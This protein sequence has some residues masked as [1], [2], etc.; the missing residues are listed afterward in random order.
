MSKVYSKSEEQQRVDFVVKQIEHTIDVYSEKAEDIDSNAQEIRKTFWEDV[1]VNFDEP[2]DAAETAASI[3]QQV[4]L[5]SERERSKGIIDKQL[6]HLSRLKNSP[7]FGRIDF[8][9]KD[10]LE[11]EQVYLGIASFMDDKH[12]QFL[13]YDWRAPISS[14]YYDYSPGTAEY[15]T[16]SGIIRGEMELKRQFIIQN[17]VIEG[18]FDT[19][20][21]IG[22]KLLQEVLSKQA[23][24]QMKN[25]V[26]TIQKEQNAIIRNE[27]SKVLVVQGV[28]GSGKTSAALQ[29]VA[30]LLYRY[31]ETLH[32]DQIMLFS[33]NPLFN[34]YIATVLPELG[35]ENM[36]QTTYQAYL[37]SRLE[38]TFHLEDAFS[39][40]ES[41]LTSEESD[42]L[43]L[44]IKTIQFKTSLAFKKLMDDYI[45]SLSKK[46]IIFNDL[47]FRGESVLTKEQIHDRFY[48]FDSSISIPNR[49][50]LIKEWI[51]KEIKIIEKK[52]RNQEWVEDE[53]GLLSKEDYYEVHKQIQKKYNRKDD[54]FNDY[55]IERKLLAKIIVSKKFKSL[56]RKMKQYQFIN[57][58]AIYENVFTSTTGSVP[59]NWEDIC[60]FS[61]MKLKKNEMTYED[62]TPYLYLQDKI[63]GKKSN[64]SI[65]HLII[66]EAQDYSPL[67]FAYIRDLFPASKMT[68]LGDINQAIHI[69]ADD[70]EMIYSNGATDFLELKR[71]YRSTRQIVEFTKEVIP[72]GDLI[73]AFNREGKKPVLIEVPNNDSLHAEMIRSI[74]AF[75]KA[76]Y[77]SIAI[78]CKT[79][80]ESS[81]AYHA[82][83]D[84]I[85]VSLIYKETLTYDTGVLILPAYLAKGIEFDAVVIYN[86]SDL[87]YSKDRERKLFY[88][89]C[90]RAM[91]ELLLFSVGEKTRFIRSVDLEKYE[92][93]KR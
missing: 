47:N 21:T 93:D 85:N 53:I 26:A 1:T 4:E 46:G 55:E 24:T 60:A 37:A 16:P 51:L 89:A 61:L 76:G 68:L 67:Q 13:I 15:E 3:K 92:Y 25:I 14:L 91:H 69:H 43:R 50:H 32:S 90:T 74:Q 30:Y 63:E 28:A 12:E 66:D 77:R 5:L 86:A 6:N 84:Q 88:T 78:I 9:E 54:L 31:R 34:S 87:Q 39:Q 17:S 48:S 82:L 8:K 2:D 40:L 19:G 71:S 49:I 58:K 41:I 20:I 62:A 33:P 7:Y 27:R 23:S 80:K 79:A 83:K 73:E 56:K 52:E 29:R 38:A 65:R 36:K 44:R 10:E 57:I 42:E 11:T 75:Q 64:T 45:I 70:N 18:M 59:T 81:E 72:G 22:D 35:E